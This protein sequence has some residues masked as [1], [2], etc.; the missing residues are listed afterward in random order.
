MSERLT[1]VRLLRVLSR[2]ARW[3]T[4]LLL[5]AAIVSC[6]GWAALRWIIVPRVD[7]FRPMLQTRVS[8][9]LGIPVR[10]A[11]IRAHA[12]G[13]FPAFELTAVELLDP[14]GRPG[15]TLPRVLVSLSPLSVWRLGFEQI[16]LDNPV[17]EIRRNRDGSL[18]V[19][20]LDFRAS[21]NNPDAAL[22]WILG[23]PEFAIHQGSVRWHDEQRGAPPLTL[24]DVELVLRNTGRQHAAAGRG[25]P[26]RRDRAHRHRAGDYGLQR[27]ARA[28]RPSALHPRL[29]LQ[30]RHVADGGA[31]VAAPSE[32]SG[33]ID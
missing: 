7:E 21:S 9:L 33:R 12:T 3:A 25:P 2:L 18:R 15:L 28:R 20:G 19:G 31:S 1:P 8:T 30:G 22:D 24:R 29:G 32:L 23:Q 4:T 16:Y 6:V 17:L 13:L 5:L 27:H 14:Q 10:I 26:A 11:A